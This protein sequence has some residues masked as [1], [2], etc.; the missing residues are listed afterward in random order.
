MMAKDKLYTF[1]DYIVSNGLYNIKFTD[2]YY[3]LSR[4]LY[5]FLYRK[6]VDNLASFFP[7]TELSRY[8]PIA[9]ENDNV[10]DLKENHSAAF[11]FT[12]FNINYSFENGLHCIK[13]KNFK[14]SFSIPGSYFG[15]KANFVKIC[16]I[17]MDY[18]LEFASRDNI[19]HF[20]FKI[21]HIQTSGLGYKA[22]QDWDNLFMVIFQP[23]FQDDIKFLLQNYEGKKPF[24]RNYINEYFPSLRFVNRLNEGFF[25]F[26]KPNVLKAEERLNIEKM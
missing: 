18:D 24:S 22:A 5:V 12:N 6:H 8:L 23:E 1:Q 26:I 4:A 9:K 15:L 13:E 21:D 25:D 14:F 3:Y 16:D 7:K 11:Y 2:V 10:H 17:F 19:K 20:D